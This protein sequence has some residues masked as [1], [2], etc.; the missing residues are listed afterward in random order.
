M[1]KNFDVSLAFKELTQE[2]EDII[3]DEVFT[4]Y[5][6]LINIAEKIHDTRAFKRGFTSPN[7][8]TPYKWRITNTAD[9]AI[10][11]AQGRHRIGGKEYGSLGWHG[12]LAP[13][14]K[15]LERDIINRTDKVKK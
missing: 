2:I 7:K 9:H 4:L 5:S 10:V 13:M 12:G 14:L 11:L 3:A 6:D 8:I 1:T 15:K